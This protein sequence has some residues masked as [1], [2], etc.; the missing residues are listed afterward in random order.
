MGRFSIA[1]V[2]IRASPECS[3]F[4]KG[5]VAFSTILSSDVFFPMDYSRFMVK[6]LLNVNYC[7]KIEAI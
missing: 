3:V 1:V 4:M 7:Q 5:L 2:G 6:G